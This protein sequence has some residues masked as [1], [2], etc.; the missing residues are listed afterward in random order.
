M[1]LTQIRMQFHKKGCVLGLILEVMVFGT[2][3]WPIESR[4]C[5]NAIKHDKVVKSGRYSVN[6]V[7]TWEY[8]Y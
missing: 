8:E 2:W 3:K 5:S 6:M 7:N 1:I 4:E